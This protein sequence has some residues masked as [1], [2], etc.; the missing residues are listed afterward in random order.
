MYLAGSLQNV[1]NVMIE[2]Q[3]TIKKVYFPRLLLPPAAVLPGIVD[4]GIAFAILIAMMLL[5]GLPIT[6]T[7][8]LV[9]LFLLLAVLTTLAVGLWLN[10]RVTHRL[11]R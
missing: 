3:S 7:V 8:L 4:F 5:Y 2:H 9:P 1:S 11:S 10:V 6:F